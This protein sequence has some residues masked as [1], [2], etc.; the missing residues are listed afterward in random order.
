M[1]LF[2]K[3][4]S[5]VCCR[6]FPE[7]SVVPTVEMLPNQHKY[8]NDCAGLAYGLRTLGVDAE[9]KQCNA[10]DQCDGPKRG[11]ERKHLAQIH[12]H[13][14]GGGLPHAGVNDRSN[15]HI[16]IPYLASQMFHH[17]VDAA[18]ERV[19]VAWIHRWEHADA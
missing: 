4:F 9:C 15:L 17:I 6:L 5:G 18:G 7:T 13:W 11:A 12:S 10:D 19:D 3:K 16:V 8:A 1:L 2:M 14:F